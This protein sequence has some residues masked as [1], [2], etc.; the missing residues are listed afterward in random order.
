M[1]G[2]VHDLG[3]LV[4]LA[5]AAELPA[6]QDDGAEPGEAAVEAMMEATHADLGA[7]VL[8]S[9]GFPEV[10]CEAVLMH[11]RSSEAVGESASLVIAVDLGNRLAKQI[12][13]GWP[14]DAAG[15]D[16][17]VLEIAA[18]LGFDFERLVDLAVD[19]ERNFEALSKLS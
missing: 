2:L 8:A 6:W 14:E 18:T 11:H 3:K 9:W 15:L 13:R 10:F 16:E 5:F 1:A 12:D 7:M 17:G 4:V 19:A